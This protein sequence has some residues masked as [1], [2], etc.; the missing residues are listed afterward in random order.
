MSENT[1][2]GVCPHCCDLCQSLLR[3]VRE[4][5]EYGHYEWCVRS[6]GEKLAVALIL[7]RAD[8]LAEMRYTIPEAIERVGA[9]WMAA[10]PRIERMLRDEG[11]L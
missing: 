1:T 2:A 6:T 4:V 7:N 10:V 5:K 8:W 9:A 11:S 3:I